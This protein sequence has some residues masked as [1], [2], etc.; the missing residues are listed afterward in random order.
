MNDV[1]RVADQ[2]NHVS[3]RIQRGKIV[4]FAVHPCELDHIVLGTKEISQIFE[5][6]RR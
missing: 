2:K 4:G 1:S 3:I 5:A 6:D